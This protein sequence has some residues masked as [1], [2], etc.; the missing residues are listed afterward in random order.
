[1]GER[2]W[3]SRIVI[4]IGLKNYELARDLEIRVYELVTMFARENLDR[5]VSL[6]VEF[7]RVGEG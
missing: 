2:Y 7:D 5:L 3:K 6:R 1:M 4:D